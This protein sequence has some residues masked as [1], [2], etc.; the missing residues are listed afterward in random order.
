[1]AFKYI[2]PDYKIGVT[3]YGGKILNPKAYDEKTARAKI[4]LYPQ[5]KEFFSF[6]ADAKP[7]DVAPVDTEKA[8]KTK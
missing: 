1:M 7:A 5:L 3:V 8:A 6:D 2:G 4:A